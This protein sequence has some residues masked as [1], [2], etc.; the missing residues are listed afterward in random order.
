[1]SKIKKLI[2]IFI[3]L[4]IITTGCR[5]MVFD[6]RFIPLL[7]HPRLV[8]EGLPS[9]IASDVL[10]A[11]ASSA[12]GPQEDEFGIPEIYG[13][14]D[15]GALSN[16]LDI[17]GQTNPLRSDW[18]G[19][20]IPWTMTGRLQA[21][22]IDFYYHQAINKHF[23]VGASWLFMRSNTSQEFILK[24][25]R[26]S[27]DRVEL[28]LGPSDPQELDEQRREMFRVIGIQENQAH[29]TGFGDI[30]AYMRLGSTWDYTLRCRSIDAG[31]RVGVLMGT[32][33]KHSINN[34]ASIPFGGNGHWGMYGALDALFEV[35]EDI[36]VGCMMRLSKRF[37]KTSLQRISV[38]GEPYVFG[39]EVGLVRINPGV[40]FV[41]SP[42]FVL[43]NLREG[44][45][46]GVY[47]T[48]TLH[49]KDEWDDVRTCCNVPVIITP[50]ERLSSWASSYFTVHVFYDFGRMRVVRDFAPVISLRWDVPSMFKARGVPKT[51]KVALGISFN[52]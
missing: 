52:F 12:C 3:V 5:A 6:N 29:Q 18:R 24:N 49:E 11:T 51:H 1:M 47:Y 38:A 41:V 46:A 31:L 23:S 15:Q 43:E 17:S 27:L 40:T 22:G 7:Q 35:R 50:T 28:T 32:G 13:T 4:L 26:S 42:W 39:A 14:F 48:L 16:A 37:A 30:D 10:F 20:K 33:V 8:I 2:Q 34:P 9:V 44:L 21:Q 36:K 45:G 25:E 19:A